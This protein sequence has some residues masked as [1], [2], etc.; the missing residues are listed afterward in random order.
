MPRPVYLTAQWSKE[1]K[2]LKQESS[3]CSL[4]VHCCQDLIKR[5]RHD[6]IGHKWVPKLCQLDLRA[7][8]SIQTGRRRYD[9]FRRGDWALRHQKS[10]VYQ[11]RRKTDANPIC[12]SSYHQIWLLDALRLSFPPASGHLRRKR[13]PSRPGI[14][15]SRPIRPKRNILIHTWYDE[16]SPRHPRATRGWNQ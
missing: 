11:E 9:P 8:C 15:Q 1:L 4:E 14:P 5:I 2:L 6:Q 10:C 12:Y 13:K 3:V 7:I 16:G